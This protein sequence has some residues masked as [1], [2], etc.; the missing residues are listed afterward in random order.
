MKNA[1]ATTYPGISFWDPK[2]PVINFIN[3]GEFRLENHLTTLG[4]EEHPLKDSFGC[5][6]RTEILRRQANIRFLT[7]NSRIRELVQALRSKDFSLPVT[8]EHFINGFTSVDGGCHEFWKH[9]DS[10][11]AEIQ[12]IREAGFQEIPRDIELLAHFLEENMNI[13]AD[14]L[15]MAKVVMDRLVSAIVYGG[16]MVMMVD[17]VLSTDTSVKVIECDHRSEHFG[18]RPFS[19]KPAPVMPSLFNY[20]GESGFKQKWFD[21]W[22]AVANWWYACKVRRWAK[23]LIIKKQPE[24]ITEAL[25]QYVAANLMGSSKFAEAFTKAFLKRGEE[26]LS[27]TLEIVIGYSL[28]EGGMNVRLLSVCPLQNQHKTYKKFKPL[29]VPNF[30]ASWW[31]GLKVERINA[32]AAE[33]ARRMYINS[34]G[35]NQIIDMFTT[36]TPDLVSNKGATLDSSSIVKVLSWNSAT[37]V[38]GLDQAL[39][40]TYQ[41]ARRFREFV[42]EKFRELSLVE[43]IASAF[44]A[45]SKSWNF[46]LHFPAVLDDREH[47][48]SFRQIMPVNLIGRKK[49]GDGLEIVA[50]DLRPITSLVP[51]CGNMLGLTGQNCGGKTVTEE[52]YAFLVFDAQSGFPLLGGEDVRLNVKNTIGMVFVERG[53]GSMVELMMR[54]TGDVIREALKHP[55]N[56]TL[57]ILDELGSGTQESKGALIGSHIL[58][59]LHEARCSVVFSTQI[60]SLAETAQREFGAKC[61]AF[62]LQHNVREGIGSGNPEAIISQLGMSELLGLDKN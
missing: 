7:D 42:S 19:R 55:R 21:F 46:G 41:A 16:T 20:K 62:D 3:K 53:D 8:S 11:L 60:T 12:V 1:S 59:K 33:S 13:Q 23:P 31:Q 27:S 37:G 29:T 50:R 48:I 32:R 38:I 30:W 52:E 58:R 51:L 36:C 54:K 56:G 24:E 49:S 9:V 2:A 26:T 22:D 14:E 45:R 28:A 6:N 17:V 25:K 10:F 44:S 15:Q 57:V 18:Y 5:A 40:E 43:R 47:L 61:F 34:I 39:L 4:L 35:L